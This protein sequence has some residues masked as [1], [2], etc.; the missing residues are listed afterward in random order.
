MKPKT[1]SMDAT[2]GLLGSA[3]IGSAASKGLPGTQ[4]FLTEDLPKELAES[5][6]FDQ[7]RY[8]HSYLVVMG[9]VAWFGYW[10]VG[11]MRDKTLPD[12]VANL[13]PLWAPILLL[14]PFVFG[15]MFLVAYKGHISAKMKARVYQPTD[16]Q[17]LKSGTSQFP[18]FVAMIVSL[19][20]MALYTAVMIPVFA[21][22]DCVELLRTAL[23]AGK[24][25]F[26]TSEARYFEKQRL[27]Y[28]V[29]RAKLGEEKA[30]KF[31]MK[32]CVGMHAGSDFNPTY[33]QWMKGGYRQQIIKPL[34]QKYG[35]LSP[36]G[37][38]STRTISKALDK[39]PNKGVR[40][41]THSI[42]VKGIKP[43]N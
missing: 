43:L 16:A 9:F 1:N 30:E 24:H 23:T 18:A 33:F 20:Q 21:L 5:T 38:V 4:K 3:M 32:S 31:L 13:S 8:F 37:H 25:K 35:L 27:H 22:Q 29:I 42:K 11:A 28:N 7:I 2:A 41:D 36:G 40:R 15:V 26:R 39:T 17:W 12:F 34:E 10:L 14:M 6:A 19:F